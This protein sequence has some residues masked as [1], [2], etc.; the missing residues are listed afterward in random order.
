MEI[1]VIVAA[2]KPYRM[3][4]DPMYL[5]LFVGSAGKENISGTRGGAL[6][7]FA[8][9]DRGENISAKNPN[10][11]ELTGVYWAWKNLN[12][13][14]VGLAHYRRHFGHANKK[15]IMSGALKETEAVKL[16]ETA[17]ILVPKK[18]RYFIETLAS[19]YSHT[20]DA[21]HLELAGKAI[22]R[23]C[24]EYT[25]AYKKAIGRTWGYMFNMFIMR[26]KYL[27]EY[28][29]F[30]FPILFELENEISTE[31]LS[32]FEARLFGRISELLFNAFIIVKKE[33]G[34][35]VTEVPMFSTEKVPWGKKILAFLMAKFSGKKYK[36]SF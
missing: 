17:D 16:F 31:G 12:A 8:R 2:H 6:E 1:R 11:C 15:D 29:E 20:H 7:V 10:F 33:Q 28:C 36:G 35:K 18:R 4:T 34:V 19:H 5:P 26:K 25:E 9:D 30:L 22:E 14:A 23:I 13:D 21:K 32:A 24:P 3:P 27:D